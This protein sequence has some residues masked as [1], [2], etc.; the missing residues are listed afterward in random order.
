MEEDTVEEEEEEE[1]VVVEAEEEEVVVEEVVEEVEEEEEEA[2]EVGF[3]R[4]FLDDEDKVEGEDENAEDGDFLSFPEPPDAPS[5]EGAFPAVEPR[6][7]LSE[8]ALGSDF[9][10]PGR[11]A[12]EYF[13]TR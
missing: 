4:P 2:E 7:P 11:D 8:R 12:L 1:E 3:E 6:L 13:C 10:P 9:G 5:A